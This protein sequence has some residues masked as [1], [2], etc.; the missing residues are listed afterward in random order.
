MRA[1]VLLR[2]EHRV[3]DV[4]LATGAMQP[5]ASHV[6]CLVDYAPDCYLALSGGPVVWDAESLL[7]AGHLRQGGWGGYRMTFFYTC[8]NESPFAITNITKPVCFGFSTHLEYCTHLAARDEAVF[9][10]SLGVDDC[11]SVIVQV[12]RQHIAT[13]LLPLPAKADKHDI[14][15]VPVD[16]EQ[17]TA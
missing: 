14:T 8:Q 9:S 4:D 7:V 3:Y 16:A 5:L 17:G 15:V 11:W 10:V 12:P 6:P 1:L 13:L 2:P